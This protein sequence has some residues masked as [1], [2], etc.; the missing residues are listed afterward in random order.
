LFELFFKYSRGTFDQ[1]E[2]LFASG[3]PSWL[4]VALVLCG[5]VML[6][7]SVQRFHQ[8]LGTVKR[9]VLCTLQVLF[10]A[11]LL[12]LLWRPALLTQT[13]RPQENSIALLVDTSASMGY[14]DTGQRSRLQQSLQALS[15]GPLP[16][17]RSTFDTELF[18][19]A[20]RTTRLES[21]DLVPAP[22]PTTD[23]GEALLT[24]LRGANAGAL[25]AVV[26]VS[27]GGD[28]SERLDAARLAE[29][30]SYGV[31]VHT[32]GVGRE[33]IP[34]D[35]ELEDVVLAP[36]G[37]PGSTISASLSSSAMP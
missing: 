26:L 16:A 4:L 32:L 2:L 33:S 5:T 10:L 25:G 13:L 22:G 29:I 3:W 34:E 14:G 15:D 28:N 20:D 24:V 30:A 19:F 8:G 7:V 1:G 36:Q 21:L 12:T 17:L 6:A 35:V 18:A 31:P 23:I 11:G 27:D 37:V 9:V